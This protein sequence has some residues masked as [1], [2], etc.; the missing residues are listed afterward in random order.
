MWYDRQEWMT[1]VPTKDT[2]EVSI[3][4]RAICHHAFEGSTAATGILV[5]RPDVPNELGVMIHAYDQ[6][7]N[8]LFMP[9]YVG[10]SSVDGRFST[11]EAGS[12]FLTISKLAFGCYNTYHDGIRGVFDPYEK[13]LFTEMPAMEK[14]YLDLKAAGKTMAAQMLLDDF[15]EQH[16]LKG[17]ELAD[18]ALTTMVEE[19]AAT[20]A[21]KK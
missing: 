11:P 18:T 8:S 16:W 14:S 9:F 7:C 1:E 5:A 3:F 21:W 2:V 13:A 10:V 4:P 6:P 12:K 20:S 15:S 19:T 17:L